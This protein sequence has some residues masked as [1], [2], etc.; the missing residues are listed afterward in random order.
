STTPPPADSTSL[1]SA[2]FTGFYSS[3]GSR[4]YSGTIFN[5][6]GR[7]FEKGS[8]LSKTVE[9]ALISFYGRLENGDFTT[10]SAVSN[11][12]GFYYAELPLGRWYAM[13]EAQGYYSATFG[14]Y[15]L[16]PILNTINFSLEK[17][18][19]KTCR[20]YG[21][22]ANA[23]TGRPIEDASVNVNG[24]DLNGESYH[25][26]KLTEI[27]GSFSF[28]LPP[29]TYRLA[30]EY[31]GLYGSGEG[32]YLPED[33][34][35][36]QSN[37]FL[38]EPLPDSASVHV[39]LKDSNNAPVDG[40]YVFIYGTDSR[41]KEYSN[42]TSTSVSGQYTI[43]APPGRYQISCTVSGYYPPQPVN[44]TLLALSNLSIPITVV[45]SPPENSRLY[46]SVR[47]SN[48]TPVSGAVIFAK[49]MDINNV[50]YE[51]MTFSDD[52]GSFEMML[53]AGYYS[54]YARKY[55][56]E[57]PPESV[58][59][60]AGSNYSSDFVLR[61]IEED[62]QVI[63]YVNHS[64]EYIGGACIVMEGVDFNGIPRTY[65][66]ITDSSGYY[67]IP[68]V[69]GEYSVEVWESAKKTARFYY[70]LTG[71]TL[72]LQPSETLFYNI[73]LRRVLNES[74]VISGYITAGVNNIPLQNAE[75]R[76][77]GVD[78]NG[79]TYVSTVYSDR[80]GYYRLF[81]REGNVV[82]NISRGGYSSVESG[83]IELLYGAVL[84]FNFTLTML[85][86]QNNP[87]IAMAGPDKSGA[88]N[89]LIEFDG[90]KS[91]DPDGDELTFLWDFG[92]GNFSSMDK[93]VH[94]YSAP[95]TYIATLKIWDKYGASS[96]A[97][98]VVTITAIPNRPP[99]AVLPHIRDN[100]TVGTEYLF[101]GSNSTDPDGDMLMFIWDFGD[102]T[103]GQ[104]IYVY[105]TYQHEGNY[106]L[107]LTV[108]DRRGGISY[109]QTLLSVVNL[110]TNR[111]PV[112]QFIVDTAQ[113]FA[114]IPVLFDAS[115][116]FDPDGDTLSYFWDFGDGEVSSGSALIKH[117]YKAQGT[118]LVVLKVSDPTG[119]NSEY[120]LPL[121]VIVQPKENNLNWGM[122]LIIILILFILSGIAAIW[123]FSRKK[124][125]REKVLKDGRIVT[126]DYTVA[127]STKLYGDGMTNTPYGEPETYD[128]YRIAGS[129]QAYGDVQIGSSYKSG[130]SSGLKYSPVRRG[131]GGPTGAAA[132]A[133]S[134]RY[135]PVRKGAIPPGVQP[136][137]A[138][139]YGPSEPLKGYLS[140]PKLEHE[141][142]SQVTLDS[143]GY[144]N[145]VVD[146]TYGDVVVENA[147]YGEVVVENVPDSTSH[148]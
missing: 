11:K 72:S 113:A 13:I 127:E 67:C 31:S 112:A 140:T 8:N 133:G 3:L 54:V 138:E 102:N 87:P 32:I 4:N 17:A 89:E 86:S 29:G 139:Y 59:I 117:T 49:G 10:V 82:L 111:K 45:P 136:E 20:L 119:D 79:E 145:T 28:S 134:Q 132:G 141:G 64:T 48:S 7:I 16:D 118:Y 65:M 73:S 21:Y 53:P 83:I 33:S 38:E 62:T 23:V 121:T 120:S 90:S 61:S 100:Y 96:S 106:I 24:Y 88:V 92:D 44:T 58:T 43:N 103:G 55:A 147:P 39:I 130:Q 75:I 76:V 78:S 25:E 18:P 129:D 95:G 1:T 148:T 52:S 94:N 51:Q 9:N 98:V 122:L 74:V 108:M 104:G 50:K 142:Y 6:T 12:L 19:E 114:G 70:P 26:T 84:E 115:S 81:L 124:I 56:L 77:T 71:I 22:V 109:S 60:S 85:Q 35:V 15:P 131:A 5:I 93:T 57:S 97:W 42:D 128:T 107:N 105:H 14:V 30:A 36:Y 37:L 34:L 91:S 46:G 80:N 101:D 135:S 143:T 63:G 27:D 41:G 144:D 47:L 99:V 125:Q 66:G 69:H 137:G 68:C 116:S 2:S 146:D 123:M 126:T 110:S 40:A